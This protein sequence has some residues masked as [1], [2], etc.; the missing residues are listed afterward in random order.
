MIQT[1]DFTLPYKTQTFEDGNVYYILGT[2]GNE[3][4][5][6]EIKWQKDDINNCYYCEYY[7]TI[8]EETTDTA[9][10]D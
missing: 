3:G 5:N 9:Y 2:S 8:E 10:L 4:S 1:V 7:W 6:D